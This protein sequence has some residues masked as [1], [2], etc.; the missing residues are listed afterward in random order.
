VLKV[1][2]ADVRVYDT[3]RGELGRNY[4]RRVIGSLKLA[5]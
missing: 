4:E 2:T 3:D 1:L 5:L